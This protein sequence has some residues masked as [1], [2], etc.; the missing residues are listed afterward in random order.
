M[1]FEASFRHVDTADVA[2]A[3]RIWRAECDHSRAF[4]AALPSF[5][6]RGFRSR[7]WFGLRWVMT[8]MIEEYPRHNGHADLLRG[9]LDGATGE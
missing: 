7:G 2:E 6:V 5:D 3:F 8:H 9:R 4:V 1:D